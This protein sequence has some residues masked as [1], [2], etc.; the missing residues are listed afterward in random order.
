MTPTTLRPRLV[1]AMLVAGLGLP[2]GAQAAVEP[3]VSTAPGRIVFSVDGGAV[4][5]NV[6]ATGATS[7]T[8]LP[9]GSTLLIGS[10]GPVRTV[11]YA[12]KIGLNG[13][14]DRGFGSGG[15]LSFPS[16]RGTTYGP[17]DVMRQPDGR[18]LLVSIS[19]TS[20]LPADPGRLQV[21]RL[22]ADLT[23]DRSYGA[24]GSATTALLGGGDAALAPDGAVVLT[25]YTGD[26]TTPPAPGT[27]PRLRWVVSRLTPAGAVDAAFGTNGLVT[28][29]ALGSANGFNVAVGPD[30][31]IVAEGQAQLGVRSRL[32]LTRLTASGALDPGFGGGVPVVV[33]LASG[34]EM[35]VLGDGSVVLTGQPDSSGVPSPVSPPSRQVLARYTPAGVPDPAFGAGG[36]VELGTDI[37][38]TQ[39]LPAAAGSVLVIG[40]PANRVAPGSRPMPARLNV[41]FVGPDGTFAG[42][43]QGITT[44]LAF[45]GGGSSFLATARPRPLASL[46][47]N[48]FQGGRVVRRA[49]GSFLA[50]GGVAI[51]QPTGEGS[52]FSTARFAAAALTPLFTLDHAFGGPVTRPRLSVRLARQRAISARTRRGIRIELKTSAVGLARVKIKR[53]NRTIA[54]SLLPVFKTTRHT[55]AVS[56][57]RYGSSY[58]RTHRNV[59]VSIT[60]TGRDL[61]TSTATATARGRLR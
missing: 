36:F 29:P 25:G 30:G 8:A 50:A 34:F 12:A 35:L 14:L 32:L 52:G 47:Q 3:E 24:G 48:G 9:D 20:T 10:G 17:L 53:A 21:T 55:L 54:Q 7:A 31:T 28:I 19:R 1:A 56:L 49:D 11:L 40:T 42:G 46:F 26:V 22:N 2:A 4:Q 16:P 51:S 61:L 27:S 39:L 45:G 18:L 60:V 44:D 58:L 5:R 43:S 23:L 15:V 57:T 13:A 59:R 41:R 33:P 38:P 37:Q 6:D